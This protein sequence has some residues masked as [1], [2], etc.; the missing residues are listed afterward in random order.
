MLKMDTHTKQIFL[1]GLFAYATTV[2]G[3]VYDSKITESKQNER[4][5]QLEKQ[6]NIL[7]ADLKLLSVVAGKLTSENA[8]RKVMIE[9]L[10]RTVEQLDKTTFELSKIAERLDERSKLNNK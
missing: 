3:L 10:N 5:S 1:T 9:T 4:I 7:E 2:T 6:T 8:A